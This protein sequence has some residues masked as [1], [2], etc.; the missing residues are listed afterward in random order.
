MNLSIQPENPLLPHLNY[1]TR[2]VEYEREFTRLSRFAPEMVHA[3]EQKAKRFVI[4]LKEEVQGIVAA[5]TPSDYAATV[6]AATLIDNHSSSGPQLTSNHST[7]SGQKRKIDQASV[8]QQ[9]SQQLVGRSLLAQAQ[10]QQLN[11]NNEELLCGSC[12]CHH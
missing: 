3:E 5:L 1:N 10:R 2:G 4:G 12:K 7:P 11:H 9:R 8:N 6:R